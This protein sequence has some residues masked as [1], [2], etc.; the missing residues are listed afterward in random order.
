M[1]IKVTSQLIIIIILHPFNSLFSRTTWVSRYQRGKTGL[2]LNEA[3]NEGVLGCS[4]VRW[5][6]LQCFESLQCFDA[7]GWVVEGHP[8]C[9][10]LSD[11]VLVWLSVCSEVDCLHMVQLMPHTH[12]HTH[13][14]NGPLSGLPRLSWKRGC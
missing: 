11:E 13:P 2:D 3:R 6:S 9:K 4:G 5:T 14:F 8:T 10:N 12:T 7:V 1:R